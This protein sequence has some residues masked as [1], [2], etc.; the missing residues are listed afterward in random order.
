[1]TARDL[2][3]KAGST[4]K[5][6]GAGNPELTGSIDGVQNGDA[7]TLSVSTQADA[8]SGVGTYPTVPH[9]DGD[10][11]V[12]A[13]YTVHATEGTLKVTA[14]DLVIKAGS[15]SK[16]YG[17]GNPEL[18]GSIDGVQNG[19]AITL[20]V[21]TQ[22]DAESGVGT[23]PTVPHADG[24]EAVLANYTVHAT[25]G[26]LKVTARDLVIKAG[27][28][29]KVYGAGNPELTGSID[30]VPNGDAITLRVLPR[31]PTRNRGWG[32]YPTVPHADGDEAVLANY[33]VHATN[34][35][36]TVTQRELVITAANKSKVYGAGN[37]PLTGSMV[38][39]QIGDAVTLSVSTQADV[40]SGVGSYPI[41]PQA[42]GTD[43]VLAN[44]K[45]EATNGTLTVT[46]RDLVITADDK[47]KVYGAANPPFTGSITGVQNGDA[48]TVW[49][50]LGGRHGQWGGVVHDRAAR[51]GR[52][53]GSGQ[54][55][56]RRQERHA[57]GGLWMGRVPPADQRH[58]AP[59][60]RDGEQ[61]QAGTDHSG[62][63]PDHGCR[64]HRRPA[65]RE[66][67]VQPD[68]LPG[69]LRR[70]RRTGHAPVRDRRQ[71]SS[72]RLQW[73]DVQL[74][75]EHEGHHEAG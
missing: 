70:D 54:L 30:G 41:V 52:R 27:S 53:R 19:D 36:L 59:D 1:M 60:G 2:V 63:V 43:A 69:G 18:T 28:T 24:D 35:T 29:S 65:D 55:H 49:F 61:V 20:R 68:R 12:F 26:T 47:L 32:T 23:Y 17:A 39:V 45:V 42:M 4:S 5:V 6:Y 37:P 44:Y 46:A 72:V 74:Q 31:R 64:R 16:V 33:T 73:L 51:G 40:R 67:D 38:G 56:G 71:R 3:I 22:A 15:T 62:Q 34:G 11:A 21:S 48:V 66:P 14:R 13:N 57:Q 58:G 25:E 9:A 8:K 75:L 10:E 50:R 7:I